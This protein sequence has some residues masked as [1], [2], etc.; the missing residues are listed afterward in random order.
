MVEI[1]KNKKT[2][3]TVRVTPWWVPIGEPIIDDKYFKQLDPIIKKAMGRRKVALGTVA[4]AGWLIENED[5]VW[6]GVTMSTQK[7]F[8]KMKSAYQND[9]KTE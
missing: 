5:G 8:K 7:E 3:K 2:G 1:W 9:P 4:Q 6:F